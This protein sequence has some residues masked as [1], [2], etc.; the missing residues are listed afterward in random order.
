MKNIEFVFKDK[1][2]DISSK[3]EVMGNE[4]T[5]DG[6]LKNKLTK[7]YTV[8][9][10]YIYTKNADLNYISEKTKSAQL[11]SVPNS[12]NVDQ[13]TIKSIV[14]DNLK[15]KADRVELRNLK[16]TNFESLVSFND[17]G[18]Y[19]V[20]KFSFDIANGNLS[21]QYK[22][23]VNTEDTVLRLI[24]ENINANDITKAIFDLDNQIYGDLTGTVHLSCN[25]ANF[26]NCMKTLEGNTSF[27]VKNGRM[28]KLGS[29]EYLLKAGN[30]VKGGITGVSINSVIDLITPLK[31]GNF[32]DIYGNVQINDGIA[33]NIEITTQ[34]K[35]LSLF[36]SGKYN[37]A[38][39]IA[40]MEV[41]GILSRK[42]STMFGP[43]GNL[44]INTLF[45]VIPG[46]DLSK[47]GQA[48]AKINKIPGIEL[49]SKSYRKFI[50]IIKGNIN[51]D[52]YVNT[53]KWI[54]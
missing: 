43:I 53:F 8:E 51:E 7:P 16:A 34:G 50:A 47:D 46:V 18:L 22:Y 41:L 30:L 5:F 17:K 39:S 3:G 28:P 11:D 1:T 2:I 54:N 36:I 10:A 15:L 37:F 52:G 38:T 14:F 27:N 23:N 33:Q 12:D 20:K 49:S 29:L 26:A 42:I 13:V 44:S 4:I 9:K 25:G 31:T 45:N 32:S 6:V 35:D 21:G 40:D 24:A 48:L 19:D